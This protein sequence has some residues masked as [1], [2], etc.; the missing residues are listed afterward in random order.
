[1]SPRVMLLRESE[2]FNLKAVLV[3][4]LLPLILREIG[5]WD[6]PQEFVFA[7]AC[8]GARGRRRSRHRGSAGATVTGARLLRV[9]LM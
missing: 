1:M 3:S 5:S 7:K 8:P 9:W 6:T 4:L 2:I